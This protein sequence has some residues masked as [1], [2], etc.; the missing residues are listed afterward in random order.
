MIAPRRSLPSLA[1]SPREFSIDRMAKADAVAPAGNPPTPSAITRTP[2]LV[3]KGRRPAAS[4]LMDSFSG[5]RAVYTVAS[6]FAIGINSH[7][8]RSCSQY[9]CTDGTVSSISTPSPVLY[10]QHPLDLQPKNRHL[11]FP[12]LHWWS[13]SFEPFRRLRSMN[14]CERKVQARLKIQLITH[15]IFFSVSNLPEDTVSA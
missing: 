1:A 9:T 2:D 8:S 15:R 7:S 10:R 11:H 3:Q 4:W 12:V 14:A 13:F 6:P 5:F